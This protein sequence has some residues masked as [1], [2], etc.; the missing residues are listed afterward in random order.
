LAV[1]AQFTGAVL[2]ATFNNTEGNAVISAAC[3]GS[4]KTK[5]VTIAVPCASIVPNL[6]VEEVAQAPDPGAFGQVHPQSHSAKY[7]GCA[8]NNKWC[9]R[10][11]EFK[12]KH[13]IGII[14]LGRT[15]ITGAN[16]PHVDPGHC[17]AIIADLTPPAPGTPH[18]PPRTTYWSSSITLAH[19][20]FH[21]SDYRAKITQPTMNSLA[22][23]ISNAA[24]CTECKSNTP[25]ATF[26]AKMESFWNTNSPTFFDG[27]H[28]VRAH[29][30]SNPMYSA[31]IAA[32]RARANAAPAAQNWPAACK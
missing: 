20:Q 31:L 24:N 25:T 9:F 27:N 10:L 16:D 3:G 14:S 21:V 1:P 7:K 15:D 30:V 6:N 23:F 19:E 8:D 29:N 17:A 28:E 18:G 4:T 2:N 22:A 32:I 5:N 26:D 13:G 12:E 11:E